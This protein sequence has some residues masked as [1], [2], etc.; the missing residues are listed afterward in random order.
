MKICFKFFC[1]GPW[2][3]HKGRKVDLES[4]LKLKSFIVLKFEYFQFLKLLKIW[5]LYF[6]ENFNFFFIF[7]FKIC[8]FSESLEIFQ[9]VWSLD[10]LKDHGYLIFFIEKYENIKKG[11]DIFFLDF[12]QFH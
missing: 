10:I 5:V 1:G 6:L 9:N 4:S 3:P 11:I 8:Q 12:E 2:K 7:N